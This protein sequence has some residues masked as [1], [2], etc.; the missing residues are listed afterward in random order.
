M[1]VHPSEL[2]LPLSLL[3]APFHCPNYLFL[4]FHIFVLLTQCG[5]PCCCLFLLP[6]PPPL[7]EKETKSSNKAPTHPATTA[8]R[9]GLMV[10]WGRVTASF[11]GGERGSDLVPASSCPRTALKDLHCQ[12]EN[13]VRGRNT[14]LKIGSDPI[15][16]YHITELLWSYRWC[17]HYK[18]QYSILIEIQHCYGR[19]K[20]S[21][22][23]KRRHGVS[24]FRLATFK[25]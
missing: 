15:N 22:N 3:P 17:S 7:E 24:F 11:G 23:L 5:M 2:G 14:W 9:K 18:V 19:T 1:H 12:R 16:S 8:A 6:L 13:N 20:P 21:W 4:S 10:N 25:V